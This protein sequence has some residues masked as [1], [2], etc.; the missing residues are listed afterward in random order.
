MPAAAPLLA[1]QAP[2]SAPP[3]PRSRRLW[4]SCP[5]AP[6]PTLA[7]PC[8]WARAAPCCRPWTASPP[9]CTRAS[10]TSTSGTGTGVCAPAGCLPLGKPQAES[11]PV[12]SLLLCPWHSPLPHLCVHINSHLN[13]HPPHPTPPPCPLPPGTRSTPSWWTSLRRRACGLW[14][15]TTRGRAWRLWSWRD[16]DSSWRRRCG[17]SVVVRLCGAGAAGKRGMQTRGRREC[18]VGGLP[19][20]APNL[21][22]GLPHPRPQFHPEFKSRPFKPSPLFLGLILASAGGWEADAAVPWPRLL[23]KRQLLAEEPAVGFHPRSLAGWPRK[24][25]LLTSCL[26][27]HPPPLASHCRQAGPLPQRPRHAGDLPRQGR[28]AA[29]QQRHHCRAHRRQAAALRRRRL[30]TWGAQLGSRA[31]RVGCPDLGLVQHSLGQGAAAFG[32]AA[33]PHDQTLDSVPHSFYRVPN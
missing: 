12:A 33:S 4:S 3:L 15:R 24:P 2:T 18:L 5:R 20:Q 27:L 11:R 1:D 16:T 9:S 14:A 26:P 6:P 13:A 23:M 29:R 7:A 19:R 32:S 10:S 31:C 21:S 28:T 30:C 22:P 17:P 25:R 8:G